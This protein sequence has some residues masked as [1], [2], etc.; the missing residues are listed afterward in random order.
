MKLFEADFHS[1]S[2]P[3]PPPPRPLAEIPQNPDL[4]VT[5]A[6]C[7]VNVKIT[8]LSVYRSYR[9]KNSLFCY[10]TAKD[11]EI[12]YYKGFVSFEDVK[13]CNKY[14]NFHVLKLLRC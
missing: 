2:L 10:L 11:N 14:S 13:V 1:I 4:R 6:V 9:K 12:N 3:S 8:S 7:N 5:N